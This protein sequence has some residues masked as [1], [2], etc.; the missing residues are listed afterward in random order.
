MIIHKALRAR[1][2]LSRHR[3]FAMNIKPLTSNW[4]L[5]LVALELLLIREGQLA[6][7]RICT[8]ARIQD[9]SATIYKARFAQSICRSGLRK[10][11][12]Q[13]NLKS[14]IPLPQRRL[15]DMDIKTNAG[16]ILTD[17]VT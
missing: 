4:S 6:L 12:Q 8:A 2:Y 5:L 7:Q 11:S 16:Y 10:N 13:Y 15:A 17:T 3:C 1:L 14:K 9:G